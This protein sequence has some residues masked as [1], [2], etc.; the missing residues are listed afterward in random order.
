MF[1]KLGQNTPEIFSRI[2]SIPSY[3][4]IEVLIRDLIDKK[5]HAI[6]QRYQHT[7]RHICEI[8]T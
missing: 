1:S 7:T 8:C 2:Q 3:K 4:R 6:Y 5:L